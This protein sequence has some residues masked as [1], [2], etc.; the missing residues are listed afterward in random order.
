MWYV[1]RTNYYSDTKRSEGLILATMWKDLKDTVLNE[2]S[3]HRRTHTAG[4]HS[5]EVSRVT[6]SQRQEV[7]SGAGEGRELVLMGVELQ[8]GKMRRFCRWM[9]GTAAQHVNVL[10]PVNCV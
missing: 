5:Q 7:A 9:V 1:Q 6:E 3:R 8:F 4:R 2:V 10:M